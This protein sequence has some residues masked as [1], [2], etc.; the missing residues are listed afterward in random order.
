MI[1]WSVLIASS[2]NQL[3]SACTLFKC[4]FSQGLT[5]D[6][7]FALNLTEVY[8][9]SQHQSTCITLPPADG[10]LLRALVPASEVST[11]ALAG[12]IP[13]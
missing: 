6:E 3:Q 7:D 4:T 12:S 8:Q 9:A 2:N 11:L 10:V 5:F 13:A 1:V